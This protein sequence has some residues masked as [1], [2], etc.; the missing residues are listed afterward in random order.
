MRVVTFI[1]LGDVDIPRIFKYL[2]AFGVETGKKSVW[3]LGIRDR[4]LMGASL[5][6]LLI[7]LQRAVND[8]L[9]RIAYYDI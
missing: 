2:Q 6:T 4:D 3:G 7:L 9:A 5:S 8:L 1:A